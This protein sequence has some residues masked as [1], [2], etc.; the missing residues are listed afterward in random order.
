MGK[1]AGAFLA[2]EGGG[3]KGGA[4]LA[5]EGRA[6]ARCLPGGLNPRDIGRDR[7]NLRMRSLLVPLLELAS[8]PVGSLRVVAALAGVARPEAR[9]MCLSALSEILKPLC[10][11]LRLEVITD[12]EALLEGYFARRDGI[13]LIAGT[14]S[15]CLGVRHTRG[16]GVTARAGGWGSYHDRGSGFR[17]GLRVLDAAL[18]ELDGR[19]Q[20]TRVV[21]MLCRRYGMDLKAIPHHFLPVSRERIADLAGVALQAAEHGDPRAQR[22]AR[23]AIHDLVDLTLAVRHRLGLRRGHEV[24]ISGGLFRSRWFSTSFRRALKRKLPSASAVAVED[25]LAFILFKYI[26]PRQ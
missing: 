26:R 10:S 15:I 3:S 1:R 14:G 19:T 8:P 20:G 13:V 21:R 2:I 9:D 16:G 24:L 22:W 12:A 17:L 6:V 4:A 7:L 23:W 25:P 11:R 5:W 18:E